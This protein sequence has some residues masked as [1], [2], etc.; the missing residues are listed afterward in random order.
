[1]RFVTVC[2]FVNLDNLSFFIFGKWTGGNGETNT[3]KK[4]KT[5]TNKIIN[6]KEEEKFEE[7]KTT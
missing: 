6:I 7:N 4:T 3:H 2:L 1:M 5:K